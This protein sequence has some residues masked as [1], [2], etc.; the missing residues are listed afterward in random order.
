MQSIGAILYAYFVCDAI[1]RQRPMS[2]AEARAARAAWEAVRAA[3]LRE[4]ERVALAADPERRRR[5][6]EIGQRRHAVWM[7][8]N[9][10]TVETLRRMAEP[11]RDCAAV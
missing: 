4:D 11:R 3:H 6:L 9:P 10:E 2:P 8:E 1:S 7:R 5:A